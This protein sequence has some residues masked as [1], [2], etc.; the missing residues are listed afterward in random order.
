MHALSVVALFQKA[1]TFDDGLE[2]TRDW[3]NDVAV[4]GMLTPLDLAQVTRLGLQPEEA[5]HSLIFGNGLNVSP[6][7]W[8]VVINARVYEVQRVTNLPHR[9]VLTLRGTSEVTELGS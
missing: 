6:V 4:T 3:V 7:D 5:T 8:R 2:I 1:D 9:T